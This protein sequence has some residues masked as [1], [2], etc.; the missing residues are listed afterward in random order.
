MAA[1]GEVVIIGLIILAIVNGCACLTYS[2]CCENRGYI[3]PHDNC[4]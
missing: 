3:G 4:V 1:F 2:L